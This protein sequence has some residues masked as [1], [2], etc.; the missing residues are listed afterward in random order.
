MKQP[1]SKIYTDRPF[2]PYCFYLEGCI[3]TVSAQVGKVGR[4]FRLAY[5]VGN[6]DSCI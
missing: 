1:S 3:L 6:E 2:Q 4:L 5:I